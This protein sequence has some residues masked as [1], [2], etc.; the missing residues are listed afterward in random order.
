M[1]R[2][3]CHFVGVQSGVY[4]AAHNQLLAHAAAVKVY[5]TKYAAEQKGK[6][7]ITLNSD[8]KQVARHTHT[9]TCTCHEVHCTALPHLPRPPGRWSCAQLGVTVLVPLT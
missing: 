6:I 3:L 8:Y 4:R 2:F 5:R 9:V 7:G 1:T